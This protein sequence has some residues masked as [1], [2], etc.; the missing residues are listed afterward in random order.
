M[1]RLLMFICAMALVFS[2]VAVGATKGK[3]TSGTAWAYVTHAEGKDLFVSG[4]FKDKLLGHG[5]IVYVTRV[6]SGAAQGTFHV[7]AKRI[8]IYT[9][10]GSLSG[11]G[12]ATQTITSNSSTVSDG[13]FLLNKGTGAYKGHTFTGTFSGPQSS[14]GE[15]TFTYK[16]TFK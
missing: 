8:T 3:K 6:T 5:G 13:K 4:D 14:N 2:G 15:Y 10:K 16:A 11:S 9:T 1:K 12:S 7:N